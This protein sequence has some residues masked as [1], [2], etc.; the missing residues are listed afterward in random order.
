MLDDAAE[1][2]AQ[3]A[4][5]FAVGEY[6][7]PRDHLH[8]HA[9]TAARLQ[10]QQQGGPQLGGKLAGQHRLRSTDRARQ[11]KLVELGAG[12]RHGQARG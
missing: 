12:E 11:V 4:L 7:R 3:P 1:P 10:D 6:L 2:G 8:R 5:G 9:A